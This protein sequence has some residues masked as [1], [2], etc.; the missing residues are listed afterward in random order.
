[1][2][3]WIT[4]LL[5]IGFEKRECRVDR[6]WREGRKMNGKMNDIRKQLSMWKIPRKMIM[7]HFRF[8][9]MFE[10]TIKNGIFSCSLLN[11]LGTLP[12][13]KNKTI[14]AIR[15]IHKVLDTISFATFHRTRRNVSVCLVC[16]KYGI[17]F[18]MKIVSLILSLSVI[19]CMHWVESVGRVRVCEFPSLRQTSN[20]I[21]NS[22]TILSGKI[23]FRFSLRAMHTRICCCCWCWWWICSLFVENAIR[24]C[25][26]NIFAIKHSKTNLKVIWFKT[27]R[28]KFDE[29]V[30]LLCIHTESEK[31][32][33]TTVEMR[34]K[35]KL[36]IMRGNE[37]VRTL[38]ERIHFIHCCNFS[39]SMW[40]H[41]L[42]HVAKTDRFYL[43]HSFEL[44][45]E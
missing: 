11:K 2:A 28:L 17:Y 40:L 29:C 18:K 27:F 4:N 33:K 35:E 1:M 10:Q 9:Q 31:R 30:L 25:A 42:I 36:C 45:G 14:L 43:I 44:S 39:S 32:R 13:Y 8:S 16:L 5:L 41:Q 23:V 12:T 19:I 34:L 15:T 3:N 37:I 24:L 38:N 22:L 26:R 21:G 6:K 20:L 7:N